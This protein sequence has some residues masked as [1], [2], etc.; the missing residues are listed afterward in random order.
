MKTYTTAIRLLLVMT[1]LTGL[2]YPLLITGIAQIIFPFKANG[3]LV[4]RN[5]KVVGSALIGQSF[6]DNKY[7]TSRPSAIKYNPL[8]S[9]ASNL[10]PTNAEMKAL[11]NKRIKAFL[12]YNNVDKN[13]AFPSEMAFA[14]A[15]GL[16]PHISLRSA[17][18]QVPRVASSRLLDST[19]IK[20]LY[21]L[22]N[23]MEEPRQIGFLGEPR[24]NVL[25]LN[26]EM[27]KKFN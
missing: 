11:F 13:A 19:R 8:P 27:D 1:L 25:L 6:D 16:D 12:E 3:S 9:G 10:G 22:V 17:L 26:L 4:E 14:S 23:R 18:L 21:Q 24:I 20:A 7:F 5:G 2:A 15:S